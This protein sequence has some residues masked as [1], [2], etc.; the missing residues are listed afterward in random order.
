LGSFGQAVSEEKTF[1]NQPIRNKNC[2]WWPYL[3]TD[4]DEMSNLYRG[5]STY[6]S[7]QISVHLAKRFQ[8]RRF[9]RNQPIRNKNCLWWLCLLL[10]RD[11]MSNLYRGPSIGASYQV[12]NHLAE[13]FQRRRI[14]CEKLTDDGHQVMAKTY[15][16]FGKVSL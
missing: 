1:K 14:K 12:S 16:A 5:P 15:V 8:R 9:F 4:Q 10:D 6:A 13:G 7:Y 2:L 11:E 3:L